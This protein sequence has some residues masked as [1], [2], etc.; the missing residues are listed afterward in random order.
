MLSVTFGAV[1]IPQSVSENGWYTLA[2]SRQQSFQSAEE[3][4]RY[5]V[6]F[7]FL[8]GDERLGHC[9]FYGAVWIAFLVFPFQHLLYTGETQFRLACVNPSIWL[10]LLLRWY[11]ALSKFNCKA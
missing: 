6:G 1:Q 9:L 10:S 7:P 3:M 8:P 4:L 5:Y 2:L 11:K